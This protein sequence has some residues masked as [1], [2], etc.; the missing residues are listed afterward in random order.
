MN[1]TIEELLAILEST[2]VRVVAQSCGCLERVIGHDL[3]VDA[4]K[5]LK[6]RKELNQ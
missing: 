1:I 6:Q 2:K 4:L 3:L 5:D